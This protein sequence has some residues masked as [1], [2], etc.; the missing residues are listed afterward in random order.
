MKV[1]TISNIELAISREAKRLL[2]TNGVEH[3]FDNCNC[4]CCTTLAEE[5]LEDDHIYNNT[6]DDAQVV[7]D[8]VHDIYNTNEM[9]WVRDYNMNY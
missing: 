2:K 1:S 6:I 5:V 7:Y 9:N 4:F 8:I 3:Y